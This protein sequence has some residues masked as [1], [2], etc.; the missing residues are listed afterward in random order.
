M[1]RKIAKALK[2]VIDLKQA[3]FCE[4]FFFFLSNQIIQFAGTEAVG[5]D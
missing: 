3:G 1:V 2:I 5:E 4:M